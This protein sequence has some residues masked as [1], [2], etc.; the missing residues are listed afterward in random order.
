MQRLQLADK[1][2]QFHSDFLLTESLSCGQVSKTSCVYE[3]QVKW[4]K[5]A[6]ETLHCVRSIFQ[7]C[8]AI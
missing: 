5:V 6:T 1:L 8:V 4:H 3:E 7:F 2:R